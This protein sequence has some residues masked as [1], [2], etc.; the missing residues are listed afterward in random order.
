MASLV[1]GESHTPTD[2]QARKRRERERER[3]GGGQKA[4]VVLAAARADHQPEWPSRLQR[5]KCILIS[6]LSANI[7][8]IRPIPECLSP[9]TKTKYWDFA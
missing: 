4:V 5:V 1:D 9:I 7:I 8:I 2:R 6:V 3:D